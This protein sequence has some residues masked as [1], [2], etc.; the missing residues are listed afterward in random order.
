MP[1]DKGA[2]KEI[3]VKL[4]LVH[5]EQQGRDCERSEKEKKRSLG[6]YPQEGGGVERCRAKRLL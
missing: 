3:M 2:E 1:F 6:I 5:R 4:A